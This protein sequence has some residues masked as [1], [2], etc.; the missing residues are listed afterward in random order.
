MSTTT[1]RRARSFAGR[2]LR[3]IAPPPSTV[4]APGNSQ[5][6]PRA[7]PA[8]LAQYVTEIWRLCL[9]RTPTPEELARNVVA[10]SHGGDPMAL[11]HET[12]ASAEATAKRAEPEAVRIAYPLGH[13]YSPIVNPAELLNSGFKRRQAADRV[14]D[15]KL[16]Y[17][18]MAALVTKAL[19]GWDRIFPESMTGNRRYY[20][21]NDMYG[22]GDAIILSAM[23][24]HFRPKRWIEVGCGF[25]SAILLDT[26]DDDQTLETALTF[27]EPHTER[28]EGLLRDT[29]RRR[30]SIIKNFVQEVPLETFDTLSAGDVLFLDTTHVSK[31]GSDVNHEI[32]HILPRLASGVI[33][34]FHDVF[35]QFEYPDEWVYTENRSWN[36]LYL[37]RAF[38][39]YNSEFEVLYANA[40]FAR[41]RVDIVNQYCPEILRNPGGG[42]WLIK[43]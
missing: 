21:D 18:S 6:V 40:S 28:L 35:D 30:V 26:L 36:E 31:M 12:A 38:L 5:P 22:I 10:L 4:V 39:M 24:R 33:I 7:D 8:A 3:R 37:L 19:Q 29:D 13:F 34:H 9:A 17:G 14:P 42:L 16:D 25:S 1:Y 2:I 11:L 15:I 23:L 27:I 32:F 41:H 43:R 20:V